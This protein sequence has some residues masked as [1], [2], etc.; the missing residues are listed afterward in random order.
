MIF[1][2][3]SVRIQQRIRAAL[4][5]AETFCSL[6]GFDEVFQAS[7]IHKDASFCA[8]AG[9]RGVRLEVLGPVYHLADEAARHLLDSGSMFSVTLSYGR[10]GSSTVCLCDWS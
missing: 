9:R 8:Q 5:E 10:T 4:P 2:R 3:P 6:R 7:K 1:K